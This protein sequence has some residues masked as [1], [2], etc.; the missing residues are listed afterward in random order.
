MTAASVSCGLCQDQCSAWFCHAYMWTPNLGTN[1][2]L[3]TKQAIKFWRSKL[4]RT[5]TLTCLWNLKNTLHNINK[6]LSK[7]KMW[8]GELY[9]AVIL[10]D[11]SGKAIISVLWLIFWDQMKHS[12][13]S[14]HSNW[15][16]SFTPSCSIICVTAT[17]TARFI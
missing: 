17:R 16:F 6:S 11:H 15:P 2:N 12:S 10:Y 8:V 5:I 3:M 7:C 14:Y 9:I 13:F 1:Q 4:Y